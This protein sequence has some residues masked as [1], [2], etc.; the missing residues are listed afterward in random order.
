MLII[1]ALYLSMVPSEYDSIDLVAFHCAIISIMPVES[2]FAA[3]QDID[4]SIISQSTKRLDYFAIFQAYCSLSNSQIHVKGRKDLQER[5]QC[6][7]QT[8]SNFLLENVVLRFRRTCQKKQ[9][10]CFFP[11]RTERA[12]EQVGMLKIWRVSRIV[13]LTLLRLVCLY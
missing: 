12:E 3:Q 7:S 8:Y 9:Q 4:L 2:L 6:L 10:A 11:P 13:L 5:L 1:T